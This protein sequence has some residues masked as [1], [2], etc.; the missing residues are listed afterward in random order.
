[1]NNTT[2]N[3]PTTIK[4]LLMTDDAYLHNICTN[5][6]NRAGYEMY[7]ATTVQKASSF[8]RRSQFNLLLCDIETDSGRGIDLL[9]QHALT[10]KKRGTKIIVLATEKH[11][12]SLC[13]DMGADF[14]LEKPLSA[15]SLLNLADYFKAQTP[16]PTNPRTQAI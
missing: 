14:F 16:R 6:I 9:R 3:N 4:A 7:L 15:K 13:E 8:L 2:S 10:L 1:M 11:F 5:I 12:Y